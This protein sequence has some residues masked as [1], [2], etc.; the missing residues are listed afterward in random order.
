VGRES[1]REDSC[2]AL[3]LSAEVAGDGESEV[4]PQS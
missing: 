3:S 2:Q 4:S 1:G